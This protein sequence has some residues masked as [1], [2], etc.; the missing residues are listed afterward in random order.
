M[1]SNADT[2]CMPDATLLPEIGGLSAVKAI[3]LLILCIFSWFPILLSVWWAAIAIP[4]DGGII[5]FV[6]FISL[7]TPAHMSI[8]A[9]VGSWIAE[10]SGPST[11]RLDSRYTHNSEITQKT[12]EEA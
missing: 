5:I 3:G 1:A 2:R 9:F 8:R 6:I 12:E 4:L 10:R 7:L 11:S